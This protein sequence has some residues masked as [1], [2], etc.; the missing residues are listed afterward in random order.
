MAPMS[1][2]IGPRSRLKHIGLGD[3]LG[4][5]VM[6]SLLFH[7]SFFVVLNPPRPQAAPEPI[8]VSFVPLKALNQEKPIVSRSEAKD[9]PPP[10]DGFKSD[11]DASVEK[12]TI[13]RGLPDAGRTVGE[14]APPAPESPKRIAAKSPAAMKR[15]A[16]S[17]SGEPKAIKSLKLDDSALLTKFGEAA[18]KTA[19]PSSLNDLLNGTA[20]S[21]DE[22]RPF[23]RPM[24][25]GARFLGDRGSADFLPNLPDG[26]ITMLNEKASRFAGFVRRVATQV[27][28]ELRLQG[29]DS[30][31]PSDII[32]INDFSTVRV[33][34]SLSGKI[35]SVELTK[36]SGSIRFDD[37]VMRASRRGAAD[38]NPPPQAKADDGAIHLI[39]Q[40][41][42]WVAGG[43]NAR[44]GAPLQR[45]WL[46]LGTGLE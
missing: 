28:A 19:K 26:D 6:V 15:P 21:I 14:K 7:I 10:I 33:I 27:F 2:E 40:A 16:E 30:L 4:F 17:K 29:W 45:R 41:K 3:Y 9:S 31:G 11:R 12:E 20:P 43:F 34:L 46:L 42:S 13:R 44:N 8:V 32:A 39:F 35:L 23:S 1:L 24:A 5:G 37:V 18:P 38:P 36:P 25:S 22:L